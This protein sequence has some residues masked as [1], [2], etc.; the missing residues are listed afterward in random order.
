M[1]G[2]Q[3]NQQA[4]IDRPTASTGP[5]AS[6]TQGRQSESN[7]AEASY[8]QL[9]S[10]LG[11]TDDD[12]PP[13]SSTDFGNTSIDWNDIADPF[14]DI[15]REELDAAI[16]S[17]SASLAEYTEHD[18]G[19]ESLTDSITDD[20]IRNRFIEGG[21]TA[22]S[23]F[24]LQTPADGPG[25]IAL[26]LD[27]GERPVRRVDTG[28]LPLVNPEP[29]ERS[30]GLASLYDAAAMAQPKVSL[31]TR[32]SA[33]ILPQALSEAELPSEPADA[34]TDQ[35]AEAET[36]V[37]A[38]PA[39]PIPATTADDT[40]DGDTVRAENTPPD[41]SEAPVVAQPASGTAAGTETEPAEPAAAGEATLFADEPVQP[42]A[43][44]ES[45]GVRTLFGNRPAHQGSAVDE[46]DH[47]SF[48]LLELGDD[49]QGGLL[50]SPAESAD[51][52]ELEADKKPKHGRI[53]SDD[54]PDN[55]AKAATAK[56][57]RLARQEQRRLERQ[58]A[59][60]FA[61]DQAR[62][63]QEDRQADREAAREVARIQASSKVKPRKSGVR[64][65]LVSV[66]VL[67]MAGGAG[68]LAIQDDPTVKSLI[69][70]TQ[71]LR[72]NLRATPPASSLPAPPAAVLVSPIP[73]DIAAA[74]PG[75]TPNNALSPA[76][77]NT[78]MASLSAPA[79]TDADRDLVPIS[80]EELE[81]LAR[82]PVAEPVPAIEDRQALDR[83][84]LGF[85]PAPDHQPPAAKP[86]HATIADAAAPTSDAEPAVSAGD[87]VVASAPQ[88]D[89]DTQIASAEPG[90]ESDTESGIG[91]A[92]TD[93][94][95]TLNVAVP[96]PPNP[97]PLPAE[98]VA[99]EQAARAGNRQAQHDLGAHYA[100]GRLVEQDF[101]RAAYWFHEAAIRGVANA[102]YNLGVLFQQGLGVKADPAL[103]V[104]WYN[105]AAEN[106]HV[107]AQYNMGVA[108]ADG[109]GVKRDI[110]KAV[111][112]F[113]RAASAGISRA[114]YNLGVMYELGMMGAPD[115]DAARQ[116]YRQA[117]TSGERD[118]VRALARLDGSDK[119]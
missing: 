34:E 3:D 41:N 22:V 26:L 5:D 10:V 102:Q 59:K 33:Q 31:Q 117:A 60:A 44:P 93:K 92:A 18:A 112:W 114:A 68:V 99:L 100:A 115:L 51:D 21:E 97:A 30:S 19:F 66:S 27:A 13:E 23:S 55:E 118:A 104:Q 76:T 64:L 54:G 70:M 39:E 58:Q 7:T 32:P 116:W 91:N 11:V 1:Q 24:P 45:F 56:Q 46:P 111:H 82:K 57:Q 2:K 42:E 105:R 69:A 87:A 14:D 15:D 53:A 4:V 80:I 8:R 103:A 72:Q 61:R 86:N 90:I 29:A 98:L 88:R 75:T 110:P 78:A 43:S 50:A 25:R 84:E 62:R 81:N 28:A 6:D 37:V 73:T 67:A 40:D 17:L 71:Q 63:R 65:A 85:S 108:Y 79:S 9:L 48:A 96:P 74:T 36:V 47:E 38:E 94:A 20:L 89:S 107:E 35:P 83:E 106:G 52:D 109:I 113:E 77:P 12:A 16:E 119:G 49:Q 101:A 95:G